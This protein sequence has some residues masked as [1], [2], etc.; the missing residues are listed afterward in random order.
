MHNRQ[1]RTLE[2]FDRILLYLDREKMR[3]EPPMLAPLRRSLE[4]SI[5]RI[6]DLGKEQDWARRNIGRGVEQRVRSLR[7][8]YMMPLVR[9]A[10]PLVTF[11]PGAEAALTVPHA[12]SD[13]L[14]VAAAALR[15]CDALAPHQKLLT[16]AGCSKQHLQKFRHDA[17]ELALSANHAQSARRRRSETTAEIAAEFR[18]AMETLTVIEGIVMLHVGDNKTQVGLWKQTRRVPARMGRPKTR[19]KRAREARV[20]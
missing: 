14:T 18:K 13:A 15:M 12:R 20:Q 3:P 17:K 11:A 16:D 2:T 9:I 1:E 7:R 5:T 8:E 19:G 10:R 4:E 6:R